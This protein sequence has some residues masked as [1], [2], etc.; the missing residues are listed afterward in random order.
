ME[1]I[2]Y[3]NLIEISPVAIEI[4]GVE[5][6]KLAVP[7]NNTLV[8]RTAF[9]AAGT[10]PYVL[11]NIWEGHPALYCTILLYFILSLAI[12]AN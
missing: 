5:N 7:V 6:G 8:R 1:G 2:T 4:Q 9:L 11:I 12:V 3:V 10:Q